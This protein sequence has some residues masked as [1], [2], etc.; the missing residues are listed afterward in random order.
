MNSIDTRFSWNVFEAAQ[1]LTAGVFLGLKPLGCAS[2]FKPNKTLLLSFQ[3]LHDVNTEH[4]SHF[5]Q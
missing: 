5:K 2:W 1:K 4:L 3:T